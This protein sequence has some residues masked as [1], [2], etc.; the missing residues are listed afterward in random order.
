MILLII[1]N[2][3]VIQVSDVEITPVENVLNLGFVLLSTYYYNTADY[4]LILTNIS[5][6]G[7]VSF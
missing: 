7:H 3:F 6:I 5:L 2:T 1:K 4:A